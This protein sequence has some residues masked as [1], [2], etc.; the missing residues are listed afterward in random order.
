MKVLFS[1]DK[2]WRVMSK[3]LDPKLN[4]A[5]LE[6]H[7]SR[8]TLANAMLVRR[9]IR[10]YIRQGIT[11]ENAALTALVKGGKKPLVGTPGA[12]LFNSIAYSIES[13]RVAE[14]GV[15]RKENGVNVGAI[16]NNGVTIKVTEKMR[17][18]FWMLWLAT[19]GRIHHTALT[20]RAK[21]LWD[22]AGKR[23]KVGQQ[24]KKGNAKK[25]IGFKP[26]KK[27]T[28]AIVIP[29]RPFIKPVI[30]SEMT[31][32]ILRDNWNNAVKAA[33]AEQASKGESL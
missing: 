16:V 13:W 19:Q 4:Q 14:V 26:L 1:L 27:D 30:E 6:K 9:D 23:V 8:A 3:V 7:V 24:G 32:K 28:V 5:T 31:R 12:D 33:M 10:G 15:S 18:M 11:P 17:R 21:E 20:G 2:G 25:G 22:L 29:P